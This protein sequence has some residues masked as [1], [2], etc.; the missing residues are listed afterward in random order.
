MVDHEERRELRERFDA[1]ELSSEADARMEAAI[2]AVFDGRRRRVPRRPILLAAAAVLLLAAA[3]AA[4]A[5]WVSRDV[6]VPATD[7]GR[8]GVAESPVLA[9]APWLITEQRSAVRI[10]EA[11]TLPSMRFAPGTT[12]REATRALFASVVERGAIPA[13]STLAPPTAAGVVWSIERAGPRLD[14]RAPFGFDPRTGVIRSPSYSLPGTLGPAE[15]NRIAKALEGGMPAGELPGVA[16]LVDTP[17]L[18]SCQRRV[19]GRV[20]TVCPAARSVE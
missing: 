5:L 15:A 6:S 14:L 3:A 1:L 19:P 20:A 18:A 4:V 17:S 12:Y 9:R 13:D 8:A 2:D 16:V 10:A 11:D 7:T